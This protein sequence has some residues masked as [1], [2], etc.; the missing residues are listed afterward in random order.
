MMRMQIKGEESLKLSL[1]KMNQIPKS[2]SQ[3]L[4]VKNLKG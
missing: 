1:T 4:V 3:K 2:K